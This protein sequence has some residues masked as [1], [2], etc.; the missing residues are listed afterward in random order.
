MA[1]RAMYLS[2]EYVGNRLGKSMINSVGFKPIKIIFQTRIENMPNEV[3]K[4]TA[5]YRK[6]IQQDD[7]CLIWEMDWS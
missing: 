1:I 5:S 3:L 4:I 6:I 7:K 2:K